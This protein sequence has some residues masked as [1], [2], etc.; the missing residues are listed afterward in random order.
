MSLIEHSASSDLMQKSVNKIT[1]H[2]LLKLRE[3]GL[4]HVQKIHS[5]PEVLLSSPFSHLEQGQS[6]GYICCDWDGVVKQGFFNSMNNNAL[7]NEMNKSA[8]HQLMQTTEKMSI[9]SSRIQVPESD[10]VTYAYLEHILG[11]NTGISHFPFVTSSDLRMLRYQ[12]QEMNPKNTS[13]EL[14]FKFGLSKVLKKA[15]QLGEEIGSILSKGKQVVVIGSSM[16]DHIRLIGIIHYCQENNI[17]IDRL[18]Y[19][20]TGRL[21]W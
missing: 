20:T 15:A 3:M 5:L 1:N 13:S 19:F 17:S 14:D 8:L 10:T 4:T 18:H 21:A 6:V 11:N 12:L 2:F 7:Q 16:V 9:W